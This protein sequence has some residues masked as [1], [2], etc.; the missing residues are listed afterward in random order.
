MVGN[1]KHISISHIGFVSF[2]N[3]VKPVSLRHVLHT[4]DLSKLLIN[5]SRLRKDNQ[6]YV[7]VYALF[8]LG[9]DLKLH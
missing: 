7:E 5:I 8:F 4:L 6:A 2:N 9:K 3:Y 1:S